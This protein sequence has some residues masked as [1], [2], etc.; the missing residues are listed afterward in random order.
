MQPSSTAV[1]QSPYLSTKAK[2]YTGFT[3]LQYIN[4]LLNWDADGYIRA[5][6]TSGTPP[7]LIFAIVPG[8]IS[9]AHVELAQLVI[10]IDG[11]KYRFDTMQVASLASNF[12]IGMVGDAIAYDAIQ[13]SDAGTWVQALKS[14]GVKTGQSDSTHA[15]KLG[16]YGGLA[17]A[18]GV[19]LI[20]VYLVIYGFVT[21]KL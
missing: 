15:L 16:L 10:T 1:P 4:I 8:Q 20:F 5:Y 11:K 19:V 6:D 3:T 21:G 9:E 7:K 18:A 13:K 17:I 2:W 14:V 12:A